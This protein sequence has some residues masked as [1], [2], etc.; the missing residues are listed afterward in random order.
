MMRDC[1][2][3]ILSHNKA[4]TSGVIVALKQR[5]PGKPLCCDKTLS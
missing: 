4:N 5:L 2:F 1:D 3:N